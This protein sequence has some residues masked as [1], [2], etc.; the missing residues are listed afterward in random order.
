L[1][2]DLKLFFNKQA[3]LLI[4]PEG[5]EIANKLL[6]PPN[7]SNLLIVPEGIEIRLTLSSHS[8]PH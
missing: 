2:Y 8:Y 4:V 5:I 1:K 3:R 6:K 7:L